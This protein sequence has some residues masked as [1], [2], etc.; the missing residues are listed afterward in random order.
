M[1][2]LNVEKPLGRTKYSTNNSTH[3]SLAKLKTLF[4][5]V[6]YKKIKRKFRN[7]WRINREI[8]P[9]T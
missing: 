2:A 1:R 5:Q 4:G 7:T 6:L 9:E 3:K 8:Y